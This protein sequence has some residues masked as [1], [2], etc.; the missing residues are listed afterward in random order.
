M[1]GTRRRMKHEI[2]ETIQVDL[3]VSDFQMMMLLKIFNLEEY[4]IE[5]LNITIRT[6]SGESQSDR[7]TDKEISSIWRDSRK[8]RKRA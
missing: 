5:Q 7:G 3:E 6:K 2:R 8:G 1:E 4:E